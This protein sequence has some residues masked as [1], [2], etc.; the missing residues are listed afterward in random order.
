VDK[1]TAIVI[2]YNESTQIR[3][4]LESIKQLTN[5]IIVVDSFSNDDTVRKALEMTPHVVQHHFESFAQQ[6]IWA[7]NHPLVQTEWVMHIDADERLSPELSNRIKMLFQQPI[8][9]DGIMFPRKTV[10][11]N[12]WIRF[13]GHFPV[14]QARLF[15][16]HKGLSEKRMYD[17]HYMID[18]DIV[19]LHEPLVNIIDSD[20]REWKRTHKRAAVW[21]AQ[22]IVFNPSRVMKKRFWKNPI[23]QRN[24]LRYTLYYSSPVFIRAFLYFFI[25]YILLFGFLDGKQ[26]MIFHYYQGFWYRILVD[27][28]VVK[29]MYARI[30]HK[31]VSY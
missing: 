7:Q 12:R 10:F 6:R 13:G 14:Y 22:E 2:T 3:E 31:C 26:G 29:E 25:R 8:T 24:W 4:C 15:R 20:M 23:E 21:E 16:K 5:A 19:C 27:T 9:C 18:G 1:I 11:R 30:G 28:H 17:Q